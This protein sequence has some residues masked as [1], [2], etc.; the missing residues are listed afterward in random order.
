[1]LVPMGP[2]GG[3][4]HDW[5]VSSSVVLW[6]V[7]SATVCKFVHA[8]CE[9]WNF[10]DVMMGSGPMNNSR[11]QVELLDHAQILFST[12]QGAQTMALASSFNHSLSSRVSLPSNGCLGLKLRFFHLWSSCTL[13]KP[14]GFFPMPQGKG[15]TPT[16]GV[17]LPPLCPLMCSGWGSHNYFVSVFPAA[18]VFQNLI[19][20][21]LVV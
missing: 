18:L 9:L 16:S 12:A 15:S 19:F 4:D 10:L 3:P 11:Q 2:A 17:P 7:S 5:Y 13:F 20:L 1:M 8:V 6:G 21:S 14:L